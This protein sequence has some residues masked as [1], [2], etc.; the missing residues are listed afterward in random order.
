MK[1]GVYRSSS[2][3]VLDFLTAM[4]TILAIAVVVTASFST[5]E[6]M[7]KKLEISQ[8]SRKYI[9]NME[10]RGYLQAV[11]EEALYRE[12]MG[13]GL[14][15]IDLT[16]TTRQAVGYGETVMLCIQGELKG[17]MLGRN[18]WLEGFEEKSYHVEEK[19][20]STAKN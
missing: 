8:I 4:I 5:M 2:G 10:T 1:R 16:G 15:S 19:R 11:T 6:L 12:L 14:T 17:S 9:L 3:N 18:W 20:M 13:A 7:V